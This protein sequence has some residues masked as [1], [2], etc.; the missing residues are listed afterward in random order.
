MNESLMI[1][2]RAPVNLDEVLA[3][4]CERVDGISPEVFRLLLSDEDAAD[5]EAGDIHPKT[6]KG[7]ALSFSEGL[8]SGRIV[9]P[10]G[11]P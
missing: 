5:I 6:L 1:E 2:P 9:V 3:A 4:A 10:G 11:E 8:R 7:Y